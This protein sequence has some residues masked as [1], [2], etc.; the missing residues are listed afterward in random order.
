[1]SFEV[2]ELPDIIKV[3]VLLILHKKQRMSKFS[4]KKSINKIASKRVR[5]EMEDLDEA[6]NEM[7]SEGLVTIKNGMVQLTSQGTRL[8]R[9][10]ENLLL[11]RDPI[12]EVV[13]GILDG[14]ITGLVVI[15][16]SIMA[17]LTAKTALFAAFLTLSAVAITN[18]SSFLL[19]GITEDLADIRTIQTL[20]NF[21]LSDI[22]D[23]K[24]RGK[25]IRLLRSLFNLLR[26]EV[27]KTNMYAAMICGTTTFIAGALPIAIY[28]LMSPPLNVIFSIAIIN[29]IIGVFL[30]YY[31]SRKTLVDWKITLI[32][33][34]IIFVIA[35]IISLILGNITN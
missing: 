20:M 22:P 27:N 30:V 32:E 28:M 8:S 21:S 34:V 4:L 10:W 12:I 17:G 9:E 14:S 13:A 18:F 33:T 5:I 6:L 24:E 3:V 29:V 16:S 1:M 7:V 19:G 23:A 11:K 25:S 31:R 15:L 26:K 2:Q 35:S